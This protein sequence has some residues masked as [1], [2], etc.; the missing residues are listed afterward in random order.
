MSNKTDDLIGGPIR[1]RIAEIKA[2]LEG[3]EALKSELE[4]LQKMLKIHGGKPTPKPSGGQRGGGVS[5]DDIV[6]LLRE[7]R[8]GLKPGEIQKR[9]NPDRD[10]K[11][12]QSISNALT[13]AKKAGRIKQAVARG[14]YMAG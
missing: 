13:L 9:L 5:Q 4:S 2:E 8:K 11:R 6:E 12:K 3:Y 7:N 10:S 1:I 14:P